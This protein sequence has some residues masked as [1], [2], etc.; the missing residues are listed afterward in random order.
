M[1]QSILGHRQ[2]IP[3]PV[4]RPQLRTNIQNIT[5]AE[6]QQRLEANE[7]LLVLDVRFPQEY[8]EDGHIAGSRLLPLPLLGQ[9]HNELPKDQSIIC[10]CRSGNRSQ[11]ACEQLAG[12]GF[13][14]LYNLGGGIIGWRQAGLPTR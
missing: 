5:P 4:A 9:R 8:A 3:I 1:L 7:P 11:A 12:L 10:V 6:L 2:R 14:N 13:T